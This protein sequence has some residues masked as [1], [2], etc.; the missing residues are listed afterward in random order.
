MVYGGKMTN[1]YVWMR[2]RQ[3]TLDSPHSD[4]IDRCESMT[5]TRADLSDRWL[6]G[7]H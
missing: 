3:K 4:V 1:G 2:R 7:R 5:W 6:D